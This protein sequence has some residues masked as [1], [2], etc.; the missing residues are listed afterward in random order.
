MSE[1][2]REQRINTRRGADQVEARLQERR[3]QSAAYPAAQV[4]R[5]NPYSP[6]FHLQSRGL[7]RS[8][9]T[10]AELRSA[11][12]IDLAPIAFVAGATKILA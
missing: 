3:T 2:A 12:V 7:Y 5:R 8:S 4:D 10:R 1:V 6:L 9:H 11:R